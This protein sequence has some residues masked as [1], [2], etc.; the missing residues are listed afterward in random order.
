M[1]D[2]STNL[3]DQTTAEDITLD[4]DDASYDAAWEEA[5]AD[6]Q[7]DDDDTGDDG[8]GADRG[9][10]DGETDEGEDSSD[11]DDDAAEEDGEDEDGEDEDGEEEQEEGGPQP[12]SWLPRGLKENWAKVPEELRDEIAEPYRHLGE[13]LGEQGRLIQGLTP[14]K[15]TL[16]ELAREM[17]ALQTMTPDQVVENMAQLARI[18]E[19]MNTDPLRGIIGLVERFGVADQFAQIFA[20]NVPP[21][22]FD[23]LADQTNQMR[24]LQQAMDPERQRMQYQEWQAEEHTRS[25]V[26]QFAEKADHWDQ[27][28]PY[29]LAAIPVVKQMQPEGASEMDV[30]QAAYEMVCGRLGLEVKAKDVP[31]ARKAAGKPDP[32]RAQKA[33]RAKSTNIS[34]NLSGKT[35]KLS[36]DEIMSRVYDKAMRGS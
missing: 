4:E 17:P 19:Q 2:T 10:E 20:G 11:E 5:T 26:I 9:G 14:I 3:E 7:E 16:T 27:A 6:E 25:E 22:Q 21:E 33:R 12:P 18:N 31:P 30:L 36:E 15:N 23:T 29:L 32:E 24:Q 13:R 1:T 34:S 35:R 8:E 28:E